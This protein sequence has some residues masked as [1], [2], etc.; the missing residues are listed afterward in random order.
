MPMSKQLISSLPLC[1]A[2]LWCSAA[3]AQDIRIPQSRDRSHEFVGFVRPDTL[4]LRPLIFPGLPVAEFKQ[5]S[6]DE[7][8]GARTILAKLPAGWKQPLGYHSA[9]LEMFVVEGGISIG[10]KPMGRYSYAYYPAGYA[11]SFGTTGGATVLQFWSG[12]PDYVPSASSRAGTDSA[13]AVDGLMYNDVPTN[14]PSSLPKF[15]NEPVMKNSPIQVKLLRLD[16]RTGQK[17]FIVTT[18]GGYPVMSGEGDLPLWSSNRTWQEGYL[19][20][21]DMT[22]A[23]CLPEGQVAGAYGPNGYFFRPA[24]IA[25]GGLSQFSETFAVWLYRTGPGHWETYRNTCAEPSKP[26]H[27][28][29]K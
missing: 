21:G 22:I 24:G 8:T 23:E 28:G 14:G 10:N 29:A 5:L 3:I 20:A 19:L 17:T 6:F 25:H 4:H 26:R 16:K 12:P 18:P 1:A 13:S 9:N 15:R 7:N 27:G 11:H 2:L